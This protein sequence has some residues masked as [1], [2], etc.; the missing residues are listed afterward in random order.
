MGV[1]HRDHE[2]GAPEEGSPL[3][4][5]VSEEGPRG[6]GDDVDDVLLEP[7]ECRQVGRILDSLDRLDLADSTVVV[8]ASDHGFHLGEHDLWA[9]TSN[10][11]LD[12]RV[13]LIIVAPQ[14]PG[15]QRTDAIVELLDLY[16]TIADYTGFDVPVQLEGR[17]LR[18]LLSD[19]DSTWDKPAISQV[20]LY[21]DTQAG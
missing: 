2:A 6:P 7:F 1:Q 17:S 9:K 10:F 3:E 20:S 12:A 11:E 13:P 15:G 8:L 4:H 19:T 5:V 21:H 18:P 16:P 14:H